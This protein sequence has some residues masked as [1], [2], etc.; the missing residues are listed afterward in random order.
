MF[1]VSIRIM[2]IFSENRKARFNYSILETFEAGMVLTGREVK[3]IRGGRINL[4]GSYVVL[5]NK[6]AFLISA[7][8]PPYQPE[9]ALL[10]Y[11][12]KRERKLLLNKKE[13]NQLIGKTKEKGLTLVPL[14]VYTKGA[15]IKLQFGVA[16]GKKKKDKRESI[17]KRDIEREIG[18]K[19][20]R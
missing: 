18:K 3:S 9:N 17:K 14:K 13:I 6:E 19:L 4:L 16:K 8:I 2:K 5:R 1:P 20:K 7:D 10:N 12:P 15:L 11:N